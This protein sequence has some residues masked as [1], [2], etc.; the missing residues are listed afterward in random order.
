M[1]CDSLVVAFAVR[2]GRSF[3][4]EL[5]RVLRKLSAWLFA[6]GL[7]LAVN[8]IPTKVN[9]ADGPSRGEERGDWL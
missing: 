8:Y 9:P 3:S 4:Y 5:L 2:K 7:H 6:G 1:F